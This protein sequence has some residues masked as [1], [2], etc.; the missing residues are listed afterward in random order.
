MKTFYKGLC[1][2]P[3][4]D[5]NMALSDKQFKQLVKTFAP[6]ENFPELLE[7]IEI[8]EKASKGETPFA[9]A[10]DNPT[11]VAIVDCIKNFK[12]EPDPVEADTKEAKKEVKKEVKGKKK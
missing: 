11:L 10:L 3:K 5:V 2:N 7:K 12:P 8:V 4:F 1:G 6:E 9:G